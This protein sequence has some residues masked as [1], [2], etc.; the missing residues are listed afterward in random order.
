MSDFP[1]ILKQLRTEYSL[2]QSELASRL[3]V[4]QNAIHQWENGKREPNSDTIEK[5][6]DIFSVTPSYLMGWQNE[7]VKIDSEIDQIIEHIV[8]EELEQTEISRLVQKITD[9][10]NKQLVI[11]NNI[12]KEDSRY[13][14]NLSDQA[15][16]F[17]RDE[18]SES[19]LE[20]IKNFADFL[21][22]K[23]K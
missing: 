4:T 2:T 12:Q 7:D 11:E 16:R 1:D 6:A 13:L 9:L 15:V 5:L 17:D 10:T 3:N 18:Y 19:E 20:E 23:R 22:S 21:K 14:N 8:N